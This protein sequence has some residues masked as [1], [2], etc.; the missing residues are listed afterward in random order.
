VKATHCSPLRAISDLNP[1]S[2]RRNLRRRCS[3]NL[4]EGNNLYGDSHFNNV[5][6]F[7]TPGYYIGCFQP[8]NS[9]H[10]LSNNS[11]IKPANL[12]IALSR[13]DHSAYPYTNK[14]NPDL[15]K[16][17]WAKNGV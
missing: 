6:S 8:L 2:V 4:K 12:L 3:G 13:R 7:G 15:Q 14:D 17:Y 16:I 11:Q 9:L 10:L 1:T 5:I